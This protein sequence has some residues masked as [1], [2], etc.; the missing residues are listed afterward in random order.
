MARLVVVH[1]AIEKLAICESSHKEYLLSVDGPIALMLD[2]AAVA[3]AP[4][5]RTGE[6]LVQQWPSEGLRVLFF[7]P[8]EASVERRSL[9]G[10]TIEICFTLTCCEL[11]QPWASTARRSLPW[12]SILPREETLEHYPWCLLFC[13][14]QRRSR[15]PCFSLKVPALPTLLTLMPF[16][17]PLMHLC[18]LRHY[19]RLNLHLKLA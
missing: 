6:I 1:K 5:L 4:H 10:D 12:R 3:V 11:H 14:F 9:P 18:H 8:Q 16:D 13:S 19:Q 17:M 2:A 7:D 15:V